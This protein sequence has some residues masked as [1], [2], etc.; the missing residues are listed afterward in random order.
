VYY[1]KMLKAEQPE[2]RRQSKSGLAVNAPGASL[3]STMS[4]LYTSISVDCGTGPE[5]GRRLAS[6]GVSCHITPSAPFSRPT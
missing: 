5:P 6:I 2:S 1:E 4:L 3:R